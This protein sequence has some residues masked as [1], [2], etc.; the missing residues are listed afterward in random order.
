MLA[1]TW[2]VRTVRRIEPPACMDARI[3]RPVRADEEARAGVGA[4]FRRQCRASAVAG[5]A[6][7]LLVCAFSVVRVARPTGD[8][9]VNEAEMAQKRVLSALSSFAEQAPATRR[10]QLGLMLKSAEHFSHS[11]DRDFT[12][13]FKGSSGGRQEQLAARI[14][15]PESSQLCEKKDLIISKFDQVCVCVRVCV[16]IHT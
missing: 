5:G 10:A 7:G 1:M 8:N 4:R 2:A 12:A 14:Q 6:L 11:F 3:V 15:L 16:Y 9:A 13:A